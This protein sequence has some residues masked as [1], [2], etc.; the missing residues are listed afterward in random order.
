[1]IQKTLSELYPKKPRAPQDPPATVAPEH[2]FRSLRLETSDDV[3]SMYIGKEYLCEIS[4][5]GNNDFC[6]CPAMTG[7]GT[8]DTHPIK[9]GD[10]KAC[11]HLVCLWR[12]A[13]GREKT[14]DHKT[15]KQILRLLQGSKD[16]EAMIRFTVEIARERMAAEYL[17]KRRI[18]FSMDVVHDIQLYEATTQHWKAAVAIRLKNLGFWENT[19]SFMP[20]LVPG[21]HR[22]LLTKWRLSSDVLRRLDTGSE[23][24]PQVTG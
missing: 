13:W 2:K 15:F 23:F 9:R 16:R 17:I 11:E 24:T 20:S 14:V 10:P 3:L 18:Y 5:D 8:R 4:Q 1:M 12:L 6:T 22:Q 21:N 7:G 19:Y